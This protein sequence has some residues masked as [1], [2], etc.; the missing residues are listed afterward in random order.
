MQGLHLSRVVTSEA[1]DLNPKP[2]LTRGSWWLGVSPRLITCLWWQALASELPVGETETKKPKN[3]SSSHGTTLYSRDS[4]KQYGPG[5]SIE[6]ILNPKRRTFHVRPGTLELRPHAAEDRALL[7]GFLFVGSCGA[8]LLNFLNWE[9][10]DLRRSPWIPQTLS[11]AQRRTR[12]K[13]CGALCWSSGSKG[14]SGSG[15]LGGLA[16]ADVRGSESGGHGFLWA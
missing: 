10:G 6:S 16:N 13:S 9:I 15:A 7:N 4:W 14:W 2:D 3:G 1:A 8:S 5:V 12:T 11:Q